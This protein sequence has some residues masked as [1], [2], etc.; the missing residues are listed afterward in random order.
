MNNYDIRSLRLGMIGGGEGAY[1]GEIHRISSR[2]DG[3]FQLVA[4]AFDVDPLR[5]RTFAARQGIS[6]DRAY[7]S[8][9]ELIAGETERE[10][11]VELVAICT[12][13]FTHY[14]IAKGLLEAGF[15]VIC[16]KPL[17][18]TIEDALDLEKLTASTGRF[19][20]VTYTYCGYPMIHE[21]REMIAR[22]DLGTLRTVQVEYPLEWMA[23]AI[24]AEGNAQAAWRTDPKK[25]GRGG[26]IGD[27]G[28]HAYHLAGF[29]TGL[30]LDCLISDLAT[31]VH[32]RQL[33]DN[34]H[35]MLRYEG[36]AR[37]LLW[38][39][40]VALGCSNGLRLRVFGEKGGLFWQQEAPNE[41]LFAPLNQQSR[42]IKRGADYLSPATVARMRTPPGHPEGYLEAFSN[43]YAGFAEAVR[44]RAEDRSPE[45]IGQNLPTLHDGV[46]GVAFVDAVV[47]CHESE[48][49]V[50][51]R[52]AVI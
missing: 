49:P 51:I 47:D 15:D 2:M 48:A 14:P 4:G 32:G 45:P 24:E 33:D 41:L 40:Q 36:G 42:T 7:G 17:T 30:K 29:V 28:T 27:I 34:A 44:S 23:E 31:F 11:R 43:L 39:S 19:L 38:A 50:W 3:S 20:G 13:N 1:I 25:N 10:D 16:E 35:V 21:A 22:G 5:G 46:K 37:G 18:T 8:Y 52:P 9:Q 6:S 26:A 12:P